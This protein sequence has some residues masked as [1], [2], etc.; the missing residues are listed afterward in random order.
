MKK[1]QAE[2]NQPAPKSNHRHGAGWK[3]AHLLEP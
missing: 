1:E 3:A 2:E